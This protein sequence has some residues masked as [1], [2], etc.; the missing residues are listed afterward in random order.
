MIMQTDTLVSSDEHGQ[1]GKMLLYQQTIS[2]ETGVEASVFILR[3]V[4][5][6]FSA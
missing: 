1:A 5:V 4:D 6:L 2:I 3:A